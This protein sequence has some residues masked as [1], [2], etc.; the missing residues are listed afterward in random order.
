MSQDLVLGWVVKVN[1]IL[2]PAVFAFLPLSTV[3]KSPA[4]HFLF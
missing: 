3:S 1:S 2:A 4:V